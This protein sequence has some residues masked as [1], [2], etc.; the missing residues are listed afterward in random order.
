MW[1]THVHACIQTANR[2]I[3][4]KRERERER[5]RE[6]VRERERGRGGGGGETHKCCWVIGDNSG[7]QHPL[8]NEASTSLLNRKQTVGK[9]K[10]RNPLPQEL[11]CRALLRL[12]IQRTSSELEIWLKVAVLW[13]RHDVGTFILVVGQTPADKILHRRNGKHEKSEEKPTR[14]AT[15]KETRD[16]LSKGGNSN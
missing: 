6:R 10:E 5:E 1:K 16:D 14:K 13:T 3:D 7:N 11:T 4:R 15:C 2:E 9:K 8:R 12:A